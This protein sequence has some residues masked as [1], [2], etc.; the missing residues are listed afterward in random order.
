M[1][2]VPGGTVDLRDDRRG[3]RWQVAVAPFL[4]GRYPVTAP[5]SRLPLVDVSWLD[6]I[7]LCDRLSDLEGLD[8]AYDR[9]PGG[10]VTCERPTRGGCTTCWATSGSGA[11]TAAFPP[12]RSTTSACG[13]PGP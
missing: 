12:S 4:L 3:T 6:A 11:G 7:D 5:D 2:S 13:S 1:V 8:R 10:E 9:T